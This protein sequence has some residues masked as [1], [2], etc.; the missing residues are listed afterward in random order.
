MA[1]NYKSVEYSATT[2]ETRTY[3]KNQEF[4]NTAD[5]I[6]SV[7]FRSESL[8]FNDSPGRLSYSVSGSHYNLLSGMR[9]DSGSFI[10]GYNGV[11]NHKFFSSGSVIYIPQQYYGQQIKVNSFE[12]TDNSTDKTIIIKD[13]GNGN[14]YSTNAHASRSAASS[15]SSSENYVGNIQYQMGVV[16]ITETGSWSGSGTT[17]NDI[18]YTDVGTGT[19]NVKF[20]ST[21][22]IHQNEIICNV[23]KNEFTATSN[24][25]IWS[26]SKLQS[27]ISSSLREWSPYAT[28][29]Q[30]YD[31]PPNIYGQSATFDKIYEINPGIN[32]FEWMSDD[33]TINTENIP[34]GI[35]FIN[36]GTPSDGISAAGYDNATNTWMG[37]LVLAGL[38]KGQ[39]YT[40]NNTL[41]TSY[42]WAVKDITNGGVPLIVGS[43]PK[44]VKIDKESDLTI[45]IR[46][47]T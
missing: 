14:L 7:Q 38:Q 15:I 4:S 29:I 10:N 31:R 25:S 9:Q 27:N 20:N 13:D 5:G 8:N 30:L 23:L 40:F 18:F 11:F 45:I 32:T 1:R 37:T 19:Y 16:M 44:A 6:S 26:G 46:Y 2:F 35:N 43:F 36:L 34:D 3:H 22:P 24:L 33:L 12:L 42:Q 47:D 41:D 21:M 17:A 39:T 28:S